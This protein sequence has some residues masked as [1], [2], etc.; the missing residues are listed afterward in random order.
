MALL[1][2]SQTGVQD[3][4]LKNGL[5][6]TNGALVSMQVPPNW[7]ARVATKVSQPGWPDQ[8]RF[9]FKEGEES[10]SG[11]GL[12]FS[13]IVHEDFDGNVKR[14]KIFEQQLDLQKG[15][16]E[17]LEKQATEGHLRNIT[18]LGYALLS[19]SPHAITSEEEDCLLFRTTEFAGMKAA[20]IGVESQRYAG[21]SIE[22]CID[23]LGN[24]TVIYSLY[25]Y[26]P[27]ESFSEL[28]PIAQ[29]VFQ[30]TKWRSD[31]DP[32]VNLAA[33]D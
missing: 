2:N 26:A 20:M 19:T 30:S 18:R 27:P 5:L 14:K 3:L 11:I 22:Y 25:C 28:L 32:T 13:G 7:I 24:G 33:V 12:F 17:A 23:V 6:K 10:K 1:D 9:F 16:R 31:F 21:K 8:T 15:S 4:V 29:E